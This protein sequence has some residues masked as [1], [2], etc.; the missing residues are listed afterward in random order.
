MPPLPLGHGDS[1]DPDPAQAQALL[2]GDFQFR[3]LLGWGGM[4]A[5]YLAEQ[6]AL[7]CPGALK[8]LPKHATPD[9]QAL[10]RFK[11]A[12]RSPPPCSSTPTSYWSST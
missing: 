6:L 11:D 12:K 10:A 7:K 4:G 1:R 5:V 3:W 8:L 9:R 2:A